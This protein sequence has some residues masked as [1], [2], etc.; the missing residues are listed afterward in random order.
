MSHLISQINCLISSPKGSWAKQ[1]N[2]LSLFMLRLGFTTIFIFFISA[3]THA[4]QVGFQFYQG[5]NKPMVSF[6][7]KGQ[8][9]SY[10][11]NFASDTRIGVWVGDLNKMSFSMLIGASTVNAIYTSNDLISSFSHS[12]LV[13]DIPIRYAF[14]ESPISSI[15]IG[16]SL[17]VL[18]ASSQTT[19]GLPVRSETVFSPTNYSLV[20][21]VAF[22]GYTSDKLN[23]H[24]YLCYRMMLNSA[25]NDGDKLRINGLSF[26]LRMDFAK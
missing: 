9:L 7:A 2:C 26:G 1:C 19:N 3:S 13:I 4:Q 21:E 6:E 16:P 8:S 20:A 25:D 12:S 15:A 17:G 5:V 10:K 23:I 18:V 11:S 14:Q 22:A 24:P